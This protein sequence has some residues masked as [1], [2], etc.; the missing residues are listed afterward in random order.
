MVSKLREMEDEEG[1]LLEEFVKIIKEVVGGFEDVG[2]AVQ[3][4]DDGEMVTT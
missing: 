1:R 4:E 2:A 3:D